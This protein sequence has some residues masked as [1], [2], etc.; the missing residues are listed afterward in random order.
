[1][2]KPNKDGYWLEVQELTR[3][4]DSR[5]PDTTDV[6]GVFLPVLPMGGLLAY[7]KLAINLHKLE[8]GGIH[9]EED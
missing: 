6:F 7:V 1:M 8:V 3:D 2:S 9:V 4:E 5:S